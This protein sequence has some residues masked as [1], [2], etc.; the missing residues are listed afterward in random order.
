MGKAGASETN[1]KVAFSKVNIFLVELMRLDRNRDLIL[2]PT[3]LHMP[4]AWFVVKFRSRVCKLVIPLLLWQFGSFSQ[5]LEPIK[6][7]FPYVCLCCVCAEKWNSTWNLPHKYPLNREQRE[8]GKD[9]EIRSA[10]VEFFFSV[11]FF[12]LVPFLSLLSCVAIGWNPH[13]CRK[14]NNRETMKRKIGRVRHIF[15]SLSL[16]FALLHSLSFT[17]WVCASTERRDQ[18]FVL[19]SSTMTTGYA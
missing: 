5:R 11:R 17:G 4:V 15:F 1:N 8:R 14:V 18:H 9:G 12:S 19:N 10:K 6:F 16:S 7:S 2:V 3:C 13:T